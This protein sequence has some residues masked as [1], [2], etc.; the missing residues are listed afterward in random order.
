MTPRRLA[1]VVL[2]AAVAALVTGPAAADGPKDNLPDD[3]RPVPPKGVEV[4]AAD[5]AEL[6]RQLAAFQAQIRELKIGLKAK[7]ALVELLPDVVIYEKAVRYAVEYGEFFN[8]KEVSAAKELLKQGMMRA[9]HLIDGKAPW[10]TATGSVVR[11]YRSKIDGSVQPYWLVVP[12]SY[13]PPTPHKFRLDFWWHG[14]G[15]TLGEVSFMANPQSASGIIPAPGTFILLPYGRYCN[16]N[17]FAGE[18]DTL[19]CLEHVKRHYPIDENRIAARGFSMG[20]AACWQFA[21]HYP[22]LWAAAAPGAGFAETPEFLNVFQ[23]EKVEPTWYEKKLWRMYNATDYALNI[24]NLPTVAYSGEIDRQKQAADVMAREM[25]KVGL[26]LTHIIGP[27][28]PHKYEPGAK[29]EVN[30]RIDAIM[31]RGRDRVPEKVKFITYTLRYNRCAWVT[32]DGLQKHWEPATVEGDLK[33]PTPPQIEGRQPGVKPV[34]L[35]PERWEPMPHLRT[36]NV[37]ALTIT[38]QP[39]DWNEQGGMAIDGQLVALPKRQSDR[40][41][42]AHYR[43]NGAWELVAS[44]E[45]NGLAKTHGLQGPIDDAFMD[46]FL[47]VRPTGEPLNTKVG[48]WAAGE[49]KHAVEHWRKQFRGDAPVKDDTAV[50][51]DDIANSNLVLWGDP[52]SNK[53]L[54]KIA[55]Q[56]PVKWTADGVKIFQHSYDT[57]T[58]VPVLIYPNP[59]NPKKYVVLNSGFTYREYDYLNN[60]RQ[61]PKLPDYAVL[62]VTTPPNSRYPGKVVRAGFFGEKWELLADDGK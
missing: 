42:T 60:A 3:V 61:V 57:G 45:P 48:A 22:S 32:I 12:A 17:K 7:P 39:G 47:M 38:F 11:G 5:L 2:L 21:V 13:V 41:L 44:A 18:I 54:A 1:A 34:A 43:N 24:Y 8:V 56:L 46:R 19:E 51:A 52:S 53:V 9:A 50:T 30:R 16:A 31:E 35:A 29:A 15:E 4:P 59:L 58:H 37:S 14:R 62:D 20:G 26:E 25:N 6:K 23:S 27:K 49:M 40:S 55:D 28:T 36:K 33:E 10:T